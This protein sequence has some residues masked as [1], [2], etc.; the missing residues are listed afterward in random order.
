VL[1]RAVIEGMDCVL[2]LNKMDKLIVDLQLTPLE[3]FDQLNKLIEIVNA[4][5]NTLVRWKLIEELGG[6]E[7]ELLKVD[8]K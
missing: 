2:V 8:E 3:A 6:D 1:R 7:E 4:S 5:M